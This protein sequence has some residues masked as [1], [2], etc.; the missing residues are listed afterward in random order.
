MQKR[1]KK[2]HDTVREESKKRSAKTAEAYNK[3]T[4]HVPLRPGELVYYKEIPKNRTKID[5]K[6]S[7]PVEVVARH[8]NAKGLPGTTYTLRFKEGET[9]TRN[10]EQLKR[11]KADLVEP[12]SKNDLRLAPAPRIPIPFCFD[13]TD[14]EADVRLLPV[15]PI[16]TRTRSRSVRHEALPTS[17]ANQ[18]DLPPTSRDQSPPEPQQRP[19]LPPP[20]S[21]V[22]STA[23]PSATAE[24]TELMPPPVII[25][26][27][28]AATASLPSLSPA[29][30]ILSAAAAHSSSLTMPSASSQLA[31]PTPPLIPL[32]SSV[33]P[34][35]SSVL[36]TA[37]S[38]SPRQPT[39]LVPSSIPIA[40]PSSPLSSHEA[41]TSDAA[42]ESEPPAPCERVTSS[43]YSSEEDAFN[44]PFDDFLAGRPSIGMEWDHDADVRQQNPSYLS[45]PAP[46]TSALPA[47]TPQLP[48]EADN[49]PSI[50]TR[51]PLLA[52]NQQPSTTST[53]L[54]IDAVLSSAIQQPPVASP[55]GTDS[56]PPVVPAT[57]SP[58]SRGTTPETSRDTVVQASPMPVAE[59][60]D[61]HP[62][63]SHEEVPNAT[64]AIAN[65][66]ALAFASIEEY[67]ESIH[68]DL[69][70]LR[71]VG[72]RGIDILV[73]KGYHFRLDRAS[74]RR[75]PVQTW[76]CR[77]AHRYRCKS[78]FKLQVQDPDRTLVGATVN[79]LEDHNHPICRSIDSETT[80][81]TLPSE[82]HDQASSNVDTSAHTSTHAISRLSAT[83]FEQD[84][85]LDEL[86]SRVR[87]SP[88]VTGMEVRRPSLE[89][90]DP[91]LPAID[92]TTLIDTGEK[93]TRGFT[94]RKFVKCSTN[95]SEVQ[96]S[97][98][99]S[100]LPSTSR[101]PRLKSSSLSTL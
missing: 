3:S 98:Q 83:D 42:E 71:N 20:P 74:H 93:D 76:V 70:L 28:L 38:I 10:Y 51:A 34:I 66:S 92:I 68:P 2:V 21:P 25:T 96:P 97:Q 33:T 16:A 100:Q 44:I 1:V 26:N 46:S 18:L 77:F 62:S 40:H 89:E 8:P 13:S 7:G 65:Q 85:A 95:V 22:W 90:E 30:P 87:S 35:R 48:A 82:Q 88:L 27:P 78:K 9:M 5:P 31:L 57:H 56:Q 11:V 60:Q 54:L 73:H 14:D 24:P 6:H 50:A 75:K 69:E 37:P 64:G 4:K 94:I 23:S 49:L 99:N 86:D 41:A 53:P 19:F 58:S 72:R 32:G 36:L 61:Q 81:S 45:D 12:I 52:S 84:F 101:I 43:H 91:N 80:S 79:F 17:T 29:T 15:A 39:P 63:L 47:S 59:D 55:Q 67:A